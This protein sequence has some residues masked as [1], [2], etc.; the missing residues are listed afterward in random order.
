MFGLSKEWLFH[1][2]KLIPS[3]IVLSHAEQAARLAATCPDALPAAVVAGDPCYDR[4]MA[5][6]HHRP[7]YRKAL[8]LR[9]SQQLILISSTWGSGSL[10]GRYPRLAATL[11]ATLP[12]D[13]FRVALALHPNAWHAHGPGQVD[14]WLADARR[15][16]LLVLPPNEGWRAAVVAADAVFGDHGSVS[17]YAA[18]LGRPVIL[19]QAGRDLVSPESPV[20]RLLS[21]AVT[22][23]PRSEAEALLADARKAREHTEHTARAWV[24][25][26]PGSSLSLLRRTMYGLMGAEEPD[27]PPVVEAAPLPVTDPVPGHPAMWAS[28]DED[29]EGRPSVRRVPAAVSGSS[30]QQGISGFLMAWDSEPDIRLA[31]LADIVVCPADELPEDGDQWCL[32]VL[33]HRAAPRA[34][35]Y[36]DRK[37]CVLHRRSGARVVCLLEA[38]EADFDP[39][40]LPTVLYHYLFRSARG[41]PSYG[42]PVQLEV[43]A[44]AENRMTVRVVVT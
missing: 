8:G 35:A 27:Q 16:G 32:R 41:L 9:K 39:A 2:G 22:Y 44:G 42:K 36:Y 30:T 29:F 15:A 26:H 25:S 13:E 38:S 18:A 7:R 34:A 23:D 14:A 37:G 28:V 31:E 40:L 5:S 3:A 11:L 24:S 19:D 1:E 6:L 4:L 21:A 10:F 33:R 43:R 20:A 17:Y 12:I